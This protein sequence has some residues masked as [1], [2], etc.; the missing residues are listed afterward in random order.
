MLPDEVR[1]AVQ[2]LAT[3]P[4]LGRLEAL[5]EPGLGGWRRFTSP[6][7]SC[8]ALSK[9]SWTPP[10]SKPSARSGHGRTKGGLAGRPSGGRSASATPRRSGGSATASSRYETERRQHFPRKA[11]PRLP[12]ALQPALCRQQISGVERT[13]I[14]PVTSGLQNQRKLCSRFRLLADL[15]YLRGFG[16]AARPAETGCGFQ[17]VSMAAATAGSGRGRPSAARWV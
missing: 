5:H 17:D 12:S 10:S 3:A 13:G 4:S 9:T 16:Q 14:E 6:A 8:G 1:M 15:A 7:D 11:F 2:N